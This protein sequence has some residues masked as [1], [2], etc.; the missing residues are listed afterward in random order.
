MTIWIIMKTSFVVLLFFVPQLLLSCF[1]IFVPEKRRFFQERSGIME[2]SFDDNN[3]LFY[4]RRIGINDCKKIPL[5]GGIRLV[6][7]INK[8]DVGFMSMQSREKYSFPSENYGILR[9]RRQISKNNSYIGAIFTSRLGLDGSQNLT[10]G[11][12]GIINLFKQTYFKVNLAQS[13]DSEDSISNSGLLDGRN[14]IYLQLEDQI[15]ERV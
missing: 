15:K 11:I 4:S 12:D 8:F 7:R 6:G 2:F 1:S 14:R 13:Y 10:Y 9:L 3:C 5:W